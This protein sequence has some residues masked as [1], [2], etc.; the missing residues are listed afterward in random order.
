MKHESTTQ[1]T[2]GKL[3]DIGI[4]ARDM[5]ETVKRLEALGIGPFLAPKPDPGAQGMYFRGKPLKGD[6]RAIIAH[7]GDANIEVFEVHTQPSPWDEIIARRGEGIHHLGIHIDDVEKEANRLA[8][9]GAEVILT[10][11]GRG[12][13]EAVYVD[14]KVANIVIELMS[15]PRPEQPFPKDMTFAQPWDA[16]VVVKDLDKAMA[17]IETLGI[18]EVI[19]GG[20]PPEGAE[21]LFYQGRLLESGFKAR[22]IRVGNMSM[23]FI[24]PD[25]K[26]NPWVDFLKTKG[27]G[28]HHVGFYAKDTEGAVKRLTALGVEVPFYGKIHGKIGAAYVDMKTANLFIEL[29]SFMS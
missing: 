14:L 16:C 10:C 25:E 21:G 26:P 23:E 20:G 27:E 18:G 13:M 17:R 29:T 7:A 12:K 22:Q 1:L 19:K 5:N 4:V 3:R 8:A 28:F 24:Q 2:N 6:F 15:Y 9:R 11:M